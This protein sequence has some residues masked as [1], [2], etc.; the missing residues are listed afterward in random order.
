MCFPL[1]DLI[2]TIQE[3]PNEEKDHTRY[4]V[5]PV[6]TATSVNNLITR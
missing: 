5:K 6:L 2:L 4:A 3:I 1:F